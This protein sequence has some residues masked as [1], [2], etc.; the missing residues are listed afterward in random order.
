MVPAAARTMV[1]GHCLAGND[2][3]EVDG[4]VAS[5]GMIEPDEARRFLDFRQRAA[6]GA[7]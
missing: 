5:C 7:D 2:A 3:A 1:A 4:D 6:G